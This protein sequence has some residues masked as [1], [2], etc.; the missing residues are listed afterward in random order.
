MSGSGAGPQVLRFGG[1]ELDLRAAEL[2]K[3][4]FKINLPD[5]PFRILTLLLERPG[6]VVTRDELRSRLWSNG[7]FVD[8]NDS[9]NSAVRRL[10]QTLGDSAEHP[11][12]VETLPRHGYR[13]TVPVQ[14]VRTASAILAP[15]SGGLAP[16]VAVLPLENL[17]GDPAQ[18][19]FVDGMTDALITALAK[20]P[21]LR[22]ISRSSVMP[23]K[24]ARKAVPEIARELQ[25]DAIVEGTVMRSGS[26]VR[27]TA[28]LVRALTD[29][30]LWAETYERELQD[31]LALQGEVARAIADEI[32]IKLTPQDQV[33][34]TNVRTVR[35]QAY[36]AYLRANY[37]LRNT[38][39]TDEGLRKAAR[40]FEEAVQADPGYAQAYAGLAESHNMLG[41]YG[42]LP[43]RQSFARA[44]EA[45]REAIGIDE[46]LSWAHAA[47]AYAL[48]M[49]DW[50][51]AV[52]EGEFKR[53]IELNP[54]YATAHHWYA[55]FLLTVGQP[56]KAI[57]ELERA[58]EIEPLSLIINVT[59]AWVYYGGRRYHQAIQQCS[60]AIELDPN[61]AVAHLC[62]GM[63]LT[64]EGRYAAAI[65]EYRKARLLGGTVHVLR[66]LGYAYAVSGNKAKALQV[67][68]ELKRITKA[69][70]LPPYAVATIYAGLGNKDQA[71]EWLNKAYDERDPQLTWLKWDPQLDGL[72]SDARFQVLLDLVGLPA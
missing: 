47:L 42:L 51:W 64:Q 32:P 69:G 13:F 60:T 4:G 50:D 12:F 33:R 22:V 3:H 5:Q 53:A 45:A 10:R 36:E 9:L 57:A 70:Y 55:E 25:V 54:R 30:H 29:H 65:E 39:R 18:E 68:Q 7:V 24:T 20:I 2:R 15:D 48:L 44:R 59:L 11:R 28:Q 21:T 34:L 26:R 67:L 66:G 8:F 72:R 46:G 56:A 37:F 43:P 63:A 31:V 35:P 58:R 14:P 40:Y 71:Y 19:Y 23:Y 16:R 49:L 27:I 17:S 61:F 1:F 6:E 62:L 38:G 52:A 41:I